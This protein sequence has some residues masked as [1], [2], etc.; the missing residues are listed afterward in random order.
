VFIAVSAPSH[1]GVPDPANSEAD[2][3]LIAC[4]AGD[5]V[6]HVTIRDFNNVPIN[7]S[8]VVIDFCECSGVTL[9]PVSTTDPYQRLGPCQI[10]KFTG[11]DGRAD[12]A[13]RAGG[14]CS[15]TRTLVFADGVL[16]AFRN[17]ASPDQ[18]GSLM[19]QPADLSLAS[20]KNGSTDPTA[21]GQVTDA[22]LALMAPHAGHQ[23]PPTDP[24]SATRRTWGGLKTI[25]R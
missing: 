15:S 2:A 14:V 3:C 11:T 8:S 13:I 16:I 1:A 25:Y 4:P 7:N 9:C 5:I 17:V 23:C 24:T 19:V 20:A 18:D 10:Q 12:F 21:D 22:D 6:F